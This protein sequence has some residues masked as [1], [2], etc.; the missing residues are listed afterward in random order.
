MIRS[1]TV[2]TVSD[3]TSAGTYALGVSETELATYHR[4]D[5]MI[6]SLLIGDYALDEGWIKT[7]EFEYEQ[8]YY[9]RKTVQV[10]EGFEPILLNIDLK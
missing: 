9:V 3:L 5:K 6:D 2:P 7:Q 8:A 10:P 1:T 4:L